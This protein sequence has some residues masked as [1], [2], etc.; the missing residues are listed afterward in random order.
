M[1]F[2]VLASLK[3]YLILKGKVRKAHN[4]ARCVVPIKQPGL[5]FKYKLLIL[6]SDLGPI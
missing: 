4:L 2:K 6:R 1:P 3:S 5:M